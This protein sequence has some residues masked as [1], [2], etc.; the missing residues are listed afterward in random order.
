MIYDVNGLAVSDIYDCIGNAVSEGYDVNGNLVTEEPFDYAETFVRVN[1]NTVNET[2]TGYYL[3]KEPIYNIPFDYSRYVLRFTYFNGAKFGVFLAGTLAYFDGASIKVYK[4][5]IQND[6]LTSAELQYQTECTLADGQEYTFTLTRKSYNVI[7]QIGETICNGFVNKIG[8]AFSDWGSISEFGYVV[9][10][11]SIF[12][13]STNSYMP[14]YGENVR[15]LIL[16]DS[17]T[18]GVGLT[19]TDYNQRWSWQI[20]KNLYDYDCVTC[21]VGG[22]SSRHAIR[23]FRNMLS[24]G[25][26]FDDVIWYLGTNDG[27]QAD[28]IDTLYANMQSYMDEMLA[29]GCRV[30]WCIPPV[31]TSDLINN[32]REASMRV[33]GAT[34]VINFANALPPRGAIHPDAAGHL[35]MYRYAESILKQYV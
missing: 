19:E 18:E 21:G 1:A 17:I 7:V 4:T 13:A 28:E 27:V 3:S 32:A 35:L 22:A 8:S 30:F 12:V 5:Y 15:C 25:Y 6:S 26:T 11:G 31:A 14:Y 24:A 16:G 33:T 9:F 29:A 23:R 2:K 34:A 20:C 10:E